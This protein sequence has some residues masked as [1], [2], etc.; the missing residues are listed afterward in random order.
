MASSRE[1]SVTED[2]NSTRRRE[3]TTPEQGQ[4]TAVDP[5]VL[6]DIGNLAFRARVIADS[7]LHG[8]HRSRHHGTSVEFAEHKEYS[9]GDDVRH[10][11]WRAYAR[12][13]RDYIKRFEDEAHLRA[14]L[15]LDT[16]GSMG[17][18]GIEGARDPRETKLEY[19]KT[20][21][22]ALAYALAR[23]GDAVG[24]ASFDTELN[25]LVPA[26][27]R[28]GHLQEVF[29]E[30]EGLQPNGPTQLAAAI[31]ALTGG[32]SRRMIVVVISDLLD[33]NEASLAAL[34]RLA[35]RKHDVALFQVL[36]S[37]E[38]DFPFEDSTLFTSIEDNREVQIDARAIRQAYLQEV[39]A[40]LKR[41]EVRARSAGI[42]HHVIRTSDAPGRFLVRFLA[43]RAS[44]RTSVR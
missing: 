5:R 19:G 22:A 43:A 23:Q 34:A 4:G 12:L 30:L 18:R 33:S 41:V 42:E 6:A 25:L 9:P 24:L 10:L 37:D 35:A 38:L 8:M 29:S 27:A 17:Y 32:M 31:N 28:R 26:R 11:D 44:R 14:L 36:D 40:F 21:A 1:T 15:L 7:V 3:E 39:G 13:D 20:L 16:S 2:S